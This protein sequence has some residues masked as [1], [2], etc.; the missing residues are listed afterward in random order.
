MMISFNA[1]KRLR[2]VENEFHKLLRSDF[3]KAYVERAKPFQDEVLKDL[4]DNCR[5]FLRGNPDVSEELLFSALNDFQRH[6]EP[7]PIAT[8]SFDPTR[9][10]DREYMTAFKPEA[11]RQL[12]DQ[13]K[14][15]VRAP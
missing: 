14:K 7:R 5:A 1:S 6:N 12:V 11:F 15:G 4:Q 8:V 9:S 10:R 13:Y 2:E 3:E